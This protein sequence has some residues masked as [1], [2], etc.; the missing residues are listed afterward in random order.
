[1]SARA[2]FRHDEIVVRAAVM[3]AVPLLRTTVNLKLRR[4]YG[5]HLD[6]VATKFLRIASL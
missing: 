4:R 1:M 3:P 6:F 5:E 2:E